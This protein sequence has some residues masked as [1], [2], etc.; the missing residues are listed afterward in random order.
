MTR[1]EAI[2]SLAENIGGQALAAVLAKGYD[3]NTLSV[4]AQQNKAAA[5]YFV[6][7]KLSTESVD[8]ITKAYSEKIID[9]ADLIHIM[10]YSTFRNGNEVDVQRFIQR[11][12]CGMDHTTASLVFV[13]DN[14]EPERF[15][16]LADK[17]KCGA[18]FPTKYGT[19][20]ISFEV[21]RVLARLKVPLRASRKGYISSGVLDI[22]EN[23]KY[24]DC[25]RG[26]D[27]KL[28]LTVKRYMDKPDW[29]SFCK[30]LVEQE[31]ENVSADDVDKCYHDYKSAPKRAKR[32]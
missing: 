2:E 9:G 17:V 18:Y 32:R 25:I 22:E 20:S 7:T 29:D 10:Q 13:A 5:Q 28:V 15:D 1:E 21:A 6:D 23:I 31:F 3:D 27:N 24:G 11:I 4:I 30:V 14:Y 26:G 16:E 12:K 8:T 19:L